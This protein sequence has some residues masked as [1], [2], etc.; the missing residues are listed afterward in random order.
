MARHFA[1]VSE[2]EI[3]T[4]YMFCSIHVIKY[5]N[6]GNGE[7]GTGNGERRTG[8]RERDSGT[9]CTAATLLRIQ[10]GDQNKRKARRDMLLETARHPRRK[11]TGH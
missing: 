9:K 3:I 2:E 10:N 4:V 6:T 11:C 1:K 7:R 5:S 8:N